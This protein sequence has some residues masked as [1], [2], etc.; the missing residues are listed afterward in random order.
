MKIPTRWK[1]GPGPK[2]AIPH[3]WPL[4]L[5]IALIAA[6][7]ACQTMEK[8]IEAN[9]AEFDG[10]PPAVQEAIRK[11][12][13]AVG[14]TTGQV[15]MALGDPY[16][17]LRDPDGLETW[18]YADSE[19]VKMTVPLSEREYRREYE[20]ARRRADDPWDYVPPR[21]Y[22]TVRKRFYYARMFLYLVEGRLD[23]WE[24]PIERIPLK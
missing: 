3:R 14:F 19:S 4:L 15:Y 24:E 10:Y 1:A 17:I 20:R 21:P 18:I 16:R 6:L 2:G 22:K 7:S 23:H 11:G 12:K 9:Q 5:L 8:R 13:V